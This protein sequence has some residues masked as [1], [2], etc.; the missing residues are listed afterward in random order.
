MRGMACSAIARAILCA[1]WEWF[2]IVQGAVLE[3]ASLVMAPP[4]N[5]SDAPALVPWV[6]AA[7]AYS[8]RLS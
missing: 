7:V 2:A 4:V 6:V 3:H 1:T 5:T 8:G